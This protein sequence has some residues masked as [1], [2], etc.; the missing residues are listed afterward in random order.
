MC[1]GPEPQRPEG[2]QPADLEEQ[3]QRWP[4]QHPLS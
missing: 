4:W 1:S 2:S 3:Q